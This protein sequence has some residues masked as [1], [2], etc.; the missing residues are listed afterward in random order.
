MSSKMLDGGGTR[1]YLQFARAFKRALKHY[2]YVDHANGWP[3]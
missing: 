3:L 2:I 1:K